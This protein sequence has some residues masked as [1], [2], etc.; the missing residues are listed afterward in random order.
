MSHDEQAKLS[1]WFEVLHRLARIQE[2]DMCAPDWTTKPLDATVAELVRNGLIK[3]LDPKRHD[4]QVMLFLTPNGWDM[5]DAFCADLAEQ[6]GGAGQAP[7]NPRAGR[8]RL[9]LA[10]EQ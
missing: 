4:G 6:G 10:Y 9:S 5:Y 7:T 2:Q 3:V 1:A 8:A